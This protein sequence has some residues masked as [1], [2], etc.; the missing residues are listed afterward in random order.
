MKQ[1]RNE[2]DIVHNTSQL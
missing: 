1:K 2:T